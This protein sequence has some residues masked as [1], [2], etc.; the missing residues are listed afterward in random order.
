MENMKSKITSIEEGQLTDKLIAAVEEIVRR[1]QQPQQEE[2]DKTDIVRESVGEIRER[3]RRKTNIL[4]F[5]VEES[6]APE[7]DDRKEHDLQ[8]VHSLLKE[9][10]INPSIEITKP[11]R[12]AKSKCPEHQEKPRPLRITVPTPQDRDTFIKQSKNLGLSATQSKMKNIYAKRDMTP[13]ER[14]EQME[15]RRR[16]LTPV[17]EESTTK[18]QEQETKANQP[19]QKEGQPATKSRETERTGDSTQKQEPAQQRQQTP[20]TETTDWR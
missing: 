19:S 18:D 15:R 7:V 12:L 1:N 9:L 20:N 3:E 2:S 10:D 16:P 13:R 17:S 5:N 11:V 4:L 8:Q 14:T 6:T